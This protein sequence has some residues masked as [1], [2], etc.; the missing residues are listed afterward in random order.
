[1]QHAVPQVPEGAF[2]GRLRIGE[3]WRPFGLWQRVA[4][5][6]AGFIGAVELALGLGDFF[7]VEDGLAVVAEVYAASMGAVM[8]CTSESRASV[9]AM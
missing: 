9:P 3:Q 7:G 8:V 2:D 6:L 1:V 4:P 5:S